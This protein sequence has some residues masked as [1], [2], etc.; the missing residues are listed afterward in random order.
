[1]NVEDSSFNEIMGS[2]KIVPIFGES[3]QKFF[4]MCLV[5][6]VLFNMTDVYGK[7]MK[8]LGLQQWDFGA[9]ISENL[10]NE[11]KKILLKGKLNPTNP[12]T[13]SIGGRKAAKKSRKPQIKFKIDVLR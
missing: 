10:Q 4:P 3:F 13:S 6:L 11:G 8:A 5:F 9:D 1:M 2:N 12:D 7:V